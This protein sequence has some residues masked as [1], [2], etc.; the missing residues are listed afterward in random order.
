MII[1][2]NPVR[3]LV[4]NSVAE[5]FGVSA[6]PRL[7]WLPMRLR[8]T[9]NQPVPIQII[10]SR[11]LYQCQLRLLMLVRCKLNIQHFASTIYLYICIDTPQCAIFAYG[12]HNQ[13]FDFILKPLVFAIYH[14]EEGWYFH[15]EQEPAFGR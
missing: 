5:S 8:V 9:G 3:L 12:K 10:E 13:K 15:V 7:I 14:R 1:Y 11:V 2:P 4:P 6:K